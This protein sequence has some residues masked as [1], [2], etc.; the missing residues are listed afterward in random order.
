MGFA[1]TGS[2]VGLGEGL[3]VLEGVGVGV[4][5]A[6]TAGMATGVDLISRQTNFFPDFMH[7]KETP[8]TTLTC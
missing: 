5:V 8:P 4:G 2:G 7:L 6:S 1:G 3:G